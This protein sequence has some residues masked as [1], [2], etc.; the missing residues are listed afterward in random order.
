MLDFLCLICLFN[1]T[2]SNCDTYMYYCMLLKAITSWFFLKSIKI[3]C[4]LINL[5][6]FQYLQSTWSCAVFLWPLTIFCFFGLG[7]EERLV[8]KVLMSDLIL[9]SYV[10][11]LWYWLLLLYIPTL[12][13]T[14]SMT[15]YMMV[16]LPMHSRYVL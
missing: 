12:L 16:L 8:I 9:Y 7:H 5:K 2:L 15:S 3:I 14:L 1:R 4:T 6:V 10:T 11:S 13:L